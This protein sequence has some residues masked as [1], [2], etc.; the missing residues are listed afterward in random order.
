MKAAWDFHAC[1]SCASARKSNLSDGDASLHGGDLLARVPF[2][3]HGGICVPSP[4]SFL[5]ILCW[6]LS[7]AKTLGRQ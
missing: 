6:L 5:F 2:L 1:S 4:F 7:Q 3:A